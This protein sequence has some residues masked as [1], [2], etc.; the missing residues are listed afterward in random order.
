MFASIV[1]LIISF[2]FC[3]VSILCKKKFFTERFEGLPLSVS[4]E[5]AET[6]LWRRTCNQKL[7]QPNS[8]N[9][10][11]YYKMICLVD[12]L[13]DSSKFFNATL[14]DFDS[15]HDW[16][17]VWTIFNTEWMFSLDLG[18]FIHCIDEV[19]KTILKVFFGIY[20]ITCYFHLKTTYGV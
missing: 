8:M 17:K 2:L 15:T 7:F 3:V 9:I 20:N 18:T 16:I 10:N 12:A 19:D 5:T 11:V 1:A 4:K 13:T 6:N 14:I